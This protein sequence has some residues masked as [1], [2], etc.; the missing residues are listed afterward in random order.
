MKIRKGK[1][2][3]WGYLIA[4]GWFLAISHARGA[5]VNYATDTKSEETSY[6]TPEDMID[7][8][9]GLKC[10]PRN[11]TLGQGYMVNLTSSEI[12]IH[13]RSKE[14]RKAKA[15]SCSVGVSYT[16]PVAGSLSSQLNLPLFHA[17]DLSSMDWSRNSIGDYD[18]SMNR[19]VSDRTVL[20]LAFNARF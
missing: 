19:L 6:K 13:H 9:P 12:Q 11:F 1:L 2:I 18:V 7:M 4:A 14:T 5:T 17:T 16:A 15:T 20:K 3:T 8:V 10:L